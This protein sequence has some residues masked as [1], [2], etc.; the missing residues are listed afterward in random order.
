MMPSYLGPDW[1][2]FVQ[3]S[4]WQ[5][6][7]LFGWWTISRMTIDQPVPRVP[8]PVSH[9]FSWLRRRLVPLHCRTDTALHYTTLHCNALDWTG[10]DWTMD[11]ADRL[12]LLSWCTVQSFPFWWR[13]KRCSWPHSYCPTA[14]GSMQSIMLSFPAHQC[15]NITCCLADDLPVMCTQSQS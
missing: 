5:C 8:Q 6:R 10:L 4:R 14:W 15:N 12:Y 9:Q 13:W 11:C 7:A 1:K 3:S 2:H